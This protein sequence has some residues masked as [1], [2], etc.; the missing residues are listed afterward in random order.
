[1]GAAQHAGWN[2]TH[3]KLPNFSQTPGRSQLFPSTCIE[4]QLQGNFLG[5]DITG[6]IAL[7]N[8]SDESGLNA[9]TV[10]IGGTL[11]GAGNIRQRRG[12]RFRWQEQA[13]V[14]TTIVRCFRAIS[15]ASRRFSLIN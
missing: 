5:L 4:S 7:P 3:L 6:A 13:W 11:P 2:N 14:L 15:S 10:T 1:M 9:S 12:W 8:C